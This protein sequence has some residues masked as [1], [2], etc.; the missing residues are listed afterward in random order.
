MK[1]LV[2]RILSAF[3]LLFLAGAIQTMPAYAQE[4]MRIVI[5]APVGAGADAMARVLAEGLAAELKSRWSS[6]RAQ[7]RV[8][9]LQR[10]LSRR[11]LPT[12]VPCCS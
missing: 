4:P 11:R 1:S 5:G 3:G 7:V 12:A 6:T 8:A 9:R 10:A 2:S